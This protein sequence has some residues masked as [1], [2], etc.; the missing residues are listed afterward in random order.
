[1]V[2][3]TS[4]FH[5]A[6]GRVLLKRKTFTSLLDMENRLIKNFND[7]VGK[8]DE[9]W[10]LGDMAGCSLDA[11]RVIPQLNGKKRYVVGNHDRKWIYSPEISKLFDEIAEAKIIAIDGVNVHLSHYP[12]LEWYKDKYGGVHLHGHVHGEKINY[13]HYNSHFAFDVSVEN[14]NYAPISFDEILAKFN[15]KKG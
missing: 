10:L 6:D 14:C 12:L 1:M 15:I 4:D 7:R 13:E 8:D 11:L 3:F 5:I 2:W 9:V